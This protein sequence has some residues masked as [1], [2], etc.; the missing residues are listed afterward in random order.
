M[1]E[2][3]VELI[4]AD[5]QRV[6]EFIDEIIDEHVDPPDSEL[7]FALPPVTVERR[8]PSGYLP[9]SHLPI[10]HPWILPVSHHNFTLVTYSVTFLLH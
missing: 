6:E 3:T 4:A 2:D 1:L 8:Y 10:S 5:E 7:P 9:I